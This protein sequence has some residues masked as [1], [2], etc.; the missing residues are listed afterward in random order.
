MGVAI[1]MSSHID[2]P[3][4]TII[5]SVHLLPHNRQ[6]LGEELYNSCDHYGDVWR[7]RELLRRGA[8]VNWRKSGDGWMPL[9]LACFYNRSDIVQE[10]LKYYPK[11]NQQTVDGDTA[12]HFAC[13]NGYLDCV[14]LLLA[15]EQCDLG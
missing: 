7:V 2:C 13:S 11:L 12:A 15:T 8:D 3:T 9:H 6:R 4:T 14:K 5:T 1:K 10:L